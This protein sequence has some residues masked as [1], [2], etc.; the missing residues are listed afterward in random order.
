M[1]PNGGFYNG[2]RNIWKILKYTSI[3]GIDITGCETIKD[4]ITILE[5]DYYITQVFTYLNDEEKIK[6]CYKLIDFIF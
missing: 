6:Y 3:R 1:V 4:L 2:K 5:K